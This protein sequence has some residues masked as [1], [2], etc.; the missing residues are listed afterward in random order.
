VCQFFGGLK[1]KTKKINND[2]KARGGK[3]A[4]KPER[5]RGQR[6]NLVFYTQYVEVILGFLACFFYGVIS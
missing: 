2:V 6:S 5:A 1:R 3:G 4:G